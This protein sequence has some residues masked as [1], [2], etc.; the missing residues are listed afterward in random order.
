MEPESSLPR[1]QVP[2]TC[3]YPEPDR[4]RPRPHIPIPEDPSQYYPSIYAWVFQV[5]S[6]P[7]VSLPKPCIRLSSPSPCLSERHRHILSSRIYVTTCWKCL[8][9]PMLTNKRTNSKWRPSCN[10]PPDLMKHTT[11]STK[12]RPQPK[13]I[14]TTPEWISNFSTTTFWHVKHDVFSGKFN[15]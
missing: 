7:Q 6:Y 15:H 12:R 3:P 8:R 9:N 14:H 2:A 13:S 11:T 1:S 5:V 4:S 10:I